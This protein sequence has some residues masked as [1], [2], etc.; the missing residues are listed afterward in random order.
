VRAAIAP[1]AIRPATRRSIDIPPL[2][3]LVDRTAAAA[4][5]GDHSLVVRQ[6]LDVH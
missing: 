6:K 4:Q 1:L 2:R 5:S 3:A